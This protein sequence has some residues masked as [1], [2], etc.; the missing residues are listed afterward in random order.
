MS[1]GEPQ[2]E[3]TYLRFAPGIFL[4]TFIEMLA[5][6]LVS[7]WRTSNAQDFDMLRQQPFTRQAMGAGTSLRR[8]KSPE[9]PKMTIVVGI[10]SACTVVLLPIAIASPH[11]DKGYSTCRPNLWEEQLIAQ[12]TRGLSEYQIHP[13]RRFRGITIQ[14]IR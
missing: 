9:A 6:L 14:R 7:E 2:P 13:Y 11:D 10:V 3:L 12:P 4:Y 5:E 8:L 1:I